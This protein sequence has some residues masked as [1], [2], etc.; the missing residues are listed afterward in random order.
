MK[1]LIYAG[2]ILTSSV[3][4]GEMGGAS[5]DFSGL[6]LG[7]GANYNALSIN[8]ASWGLGISNVANAGVLTSTGIAQG[9]AAP[10][11]NISL[12]FAPEV[13]ASYLKNYN[14]MYYGQVFLINI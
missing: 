10:F 6:S 5:L 1:K 11:Q 2:C 7:L 4:A 3:F 9:N 12:N 14:S 8:Q 13:K